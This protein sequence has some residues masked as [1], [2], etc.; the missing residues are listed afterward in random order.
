MMR[1]REAAAR[2]YSPPPPPPLPPPP[3]IR[4]GPRT[5]AVM[6]TLRGEDRH[7]TARR[8]CSRSIK[9]RMPVAC[10]GSLSSRVLATLRASSRAG[11]FPT[12]G[13]SCERQYEV[14]RSPPP[15]RD[16]RAPLRESCSRVGP[17]SATAPCETPLHWSI[18]PKFPRWTPAAERRRGQFAP[19]AQLAGRRLFRFEAASH[20]LT[21]RPRVDVRV[22][23]FTKKNQN[24]FSLPQGSPHCPSSVR[25]RQTPRRAKHPLDSVPAFVEVVSGRQGQPID[26]SRACRDRPRAFRHRDKCLRRVARSVFQAALQS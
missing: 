23:A 19:R 8:R 15:A 16:L 6:I 2:T 25:G 9:A 26:F 13:P 17:Q 22:G 3:P 21:G 18:T 14:A 5:L 7:C 10:A 12:E 1:G 24:K 4:L 20:Y 11:T